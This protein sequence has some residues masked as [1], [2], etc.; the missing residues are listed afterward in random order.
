MGSADLMHRNLDRR[1][2]ALVRVTDPAAQAELRRVF[3]SSMRAQ[4]AGFD[5]DSAGD[6]HRR[7][8][9]GGVPLD[10]LQELM[11]RRAQGRPD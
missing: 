4:T 9:E 2:E 7:V 11:L 10:D 1:V 5:L 3:D 8:A 6:W